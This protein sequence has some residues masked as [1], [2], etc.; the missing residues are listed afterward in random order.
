MAERS[1]TLFDA[2]DSG[3]SRSLTA[4]V[5]EA[6]DLRLVQL[7]GGP[8][9]SQA[10]GPSVGW[11]EYNVGVKAEELPKLVA[12]L[13]GRPGDDVLGLLQARYRAGTWDDRVHP[14]MEAMDAASIEYSHLSW[15]D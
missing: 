14:L 5:G 10:W 12:M 15:I 9:V 1:V 8:A 11:S 4:T 7:H 13:G 3:G 6:G 2:R